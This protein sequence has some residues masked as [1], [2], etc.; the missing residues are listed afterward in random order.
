MFSCIG[1]L[2]EHGPLAYFVRSHLITN[3]MTWLLL[4]RGFQSP[5]RDK[6]VNKSLL[7]YVSQKNS[8][9]KKF[10]DLGGST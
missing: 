4:S 10:P 3:E 9:K 2:Y 1:L 7:Y 6:H 8:L 5:R